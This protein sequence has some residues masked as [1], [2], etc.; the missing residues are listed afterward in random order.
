MSMG[1]LAKFHLGQWRGI[2]KAIY[3]SRRAA[4]DLT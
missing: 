1:R 3:P 2:G 4:D